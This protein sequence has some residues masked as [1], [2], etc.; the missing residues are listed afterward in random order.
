[1]LPLFKKKSYDWSEFMPK[2]YKVML[3]G[4]GSLIL[5]YLAYVGFISYD[6]AKKAYSVAFY[7][8]NEKGFTNTK[9]SKDNLILEKK[10]EVERIVKIVRG[11]N[12]EPGIPSIASPKILL[13]INKKSGK[14]EEYY[15]WCDSPWG[16]ASLMPTTDSNA[17][18]SISNVDTTY[19]REILMT[20]GYFKEDKKT[21]TE[22]LVADSYIDSKYDTARIV[23]VSKDARYFIINYVDGELNDN[24]LFIFWDNLDKKEISRGR[25]KTTY[26]YENIRNIVP[27]EFKKEFI[28]NAIEYKHIEKP[29]D[30]P[31]TMEIVSSWSYSAYSP[32]KKRIYYNHGKTPLELMIYNVESKKHLPIITANRIIDSE[33]RNEI[34]L[35]SWWLEDGSIFTITMIGKWNDTNFKSNCA[36]IIKFNDGEIN[37]MLDN[38]EIYKHLLKYYGSEKTMEGHDRIVNMLTT[39]IN[40][41][42]PFEDGFLVLITHKHKK[43]ELGLFYMKVGEGIIKKYTGEYPKNYDVSINHAV[44]NGKNIVFGRTSDLI[45]NSKN[46]SQEAWY[47]RIEVELSNGES[48]VK[49]FIPEA[50]Y[51][52]NGFILIDDEAKKVRKIK[53]FNLQGDVIKNES[54]GF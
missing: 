48:Y 43:E 54:V 32:D 41:V 44:I 46:Q 4:I 30:M 37:K 26:K 1:M 38:A 40:N 24:N 49:T 52:K 9:I 39:Q 21:H 16:K 28:D 15:L 35:R 14:N 51:S 17:L 50:G 19:L 8:I 18:Y 2:K 34:R 22:I 3:L 42:V 27:N 13:S 7:S 31:D 47:S 33:L 10:D 25:I 36:K 5:I 29:K 23:D 12:R 11:A 53:F 20:V 6:D 45:L